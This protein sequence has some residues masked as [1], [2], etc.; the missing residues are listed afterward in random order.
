M[1]ADP[2]VANRTPAQFPGKSIGDQQDIVDPLMAVLRGLNILPTAD[3]KAANSFFWAFQ[4]TPTSVAVLESGATALSKGWAI[5]IG[6]LGGATVITAAV[7]GFWKSQT[8]AVHVVLIAGTSLTIIAAIAAIV[9]MVRSDINSRTQ[10]SIAIYEARKSIALEFMRQSL[11][12]AEGS[13]GAASANPISPSATVV[14]LAIGGRRA[15]VQHTSGAQGHLAGFKHYNRGVE[16]AWVKIGDSEANWSPPG[17]LQ[18]VQ[19]T[20]PYQK[21]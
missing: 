8:G 6:A 10:G 11:T 17:D 1:P 15:L 21:P 4:G 5:V 19:F 3:D 7:N 18:V 16:V 9:M 20:Y 12:A 14:S 2:D 13:L